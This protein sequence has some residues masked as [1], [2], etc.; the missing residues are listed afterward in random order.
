MKLKNVPWLNNV[1]SKHQKD[2]KKVTQ[3]INSYCDLVGT[4]F[5]NNDSSSDDESNV[6]TQVDEDNQV[7]KTSYRLS[8][9][10]Y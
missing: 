8:L 3:N 5:E 1:T 10:Y 7:L 2:T 9:Y 4:I 6:A